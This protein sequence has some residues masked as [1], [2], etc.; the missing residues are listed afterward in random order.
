MIPSCKTSDQLRGLQTL[1]VGEPILDA[2][3]PCERQAHTKTVPVR[4][5]RSAS[6]P[7]DPPRRRCFHGHLGFHVDAMEQNTRSARWPPDPRP[8]RRNP[9]AVWPAPSGL[10]RSRECNK[11]VKQ[12]CHFLKYEER[13]SEKTREGGR[14]NNGHSN[15]V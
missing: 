14:K 9:C 7:D 6:K 5:S 12:T 8:T 3:G 11:V 15:P 2:R 4:T 1:C 10:T 13:L